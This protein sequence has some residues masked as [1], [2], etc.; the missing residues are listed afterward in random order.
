MS[1][2]DVID[3]TI[4]VSATGGTGTLSYTL[5]PDLVM[6]FSGIFTGLNEGN[7]YV[8]VKDQNQCPALSETLTIVNPE[9]IEIVSETYTNPLCAGSANGSITVVAAGGTEPW[10][11]LLNPGNIPDPDGQ[12][13]NLGP[14]V[15]TVT[16]TDT[17]QCPFAVSQPITITD[18]PVL[19][20]IT[21]EFTPISCHNAHDGSIEV[22]ASGGTGPINYTLLPDNLTQTAGVFHNLGPGSYQVIAEDAQGCQ[23]SGNSFILLNPDPVEIL[24]IVL[25]HP[26]C[27]GS[28]DGSITI[29]AQGGTGNLEYS[30]DGGIV[31]QAL[32]TF[33]NLNAGYYILSVRDANSC[34]AFYTGDPV[35]LIQPALLEL[36]FQQTHPSCNGCYDGMITALPSG[37]TPPY[38]HSWN[39]GA[40]T[41]SITGLGANIYYVDTLTDLNGCIRIDSTILYEPGVFEVNILSGN[42][43]CFGGQDG[44]ISATPAGGTPPYQYAWA[45]LPDPSIIST[46]SLLANRTAGQYSL[47]VTDAFGYFVADTIEITESPALDIQLLVSADSLCPESSEGWILAM[48]SGGSTAYNYAWNAGTYLPSRPD[49]LFQLTP[50]E[51]TL[52]ITDAMG[53]QATASRQL[54]AYNSPLAACDVSNGCALY[55][56]FFDESSTGGGAQIIR[57]YYDFG[58]GQNQ[59]VQPPDNP[60]ITHIYE[61]AETYFPALVVTNT[62]GCISDTSRLTLTISPLPQAS[63]AYTQVCLGNPTQFTNTSS[64]SGGQIAETY[65]DFGDGI[66]SGITNPSHTFATAGYHTVTLIVISNA[67][68]TDTLSQEVW[69]HPRPDAGFT[70]SPIC[71]SLIVQFSDTSNPFGASLVQWQWEFGDGNSSSLQNPLHAYSAIGSYPVSLIVSTEAGCTDTAFSTLSLEA[72]WTAGFI[73]DTACFGDTTHFQAYVNPSGVPIQIVTWNFGDGQSGTGW[74]PSHAYALPE[75]GRASCRERV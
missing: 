51:Y 43:S 75:I 4:T 63:F 61:N 69:V 48:V 2:H 31:Y 40:Q 23:I 64:V 14:G 26:S 34:Q 5:Y 55:P 45:K 13:I 25:H 19:S 74:N 42:V 9:P 41:A 59:T 73:F 47:I 38:Q 62:H 29:F 70:W 30:I 12:F 37:G 46:D 7:K 53:C 8:I 54:Y 1:C 27:Q 24:Q 17:H 28:F 22:Q 50:G 11:F 3:G 36:S 58:D 56:V 39:T 72:P 52:I 20:F 6:N 21:E 33:S 68:C 65:W 18:P 71:N 67:N 15:Y 44:W 66:T 16:V 60:D 32:E 10:V 35:Q 49:S 57:W